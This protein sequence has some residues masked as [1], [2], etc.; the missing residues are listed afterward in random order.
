MC[1]T[2]DNVTR[3]YEEANE[4]SRK[5]LLVWIKALEPK[6]QEDENLIDDL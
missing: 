3:N 5:I 6:Y 2:S 1:L 4:N